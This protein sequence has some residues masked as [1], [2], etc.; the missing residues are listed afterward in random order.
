VPD[1]KSRAVK[2]ANDPDEDNTPSAANN[3]ALAAESSIQER[4]R[5]PRST[6]GE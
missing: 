5:R 4:R 1:A 3:P 2:I 6:T